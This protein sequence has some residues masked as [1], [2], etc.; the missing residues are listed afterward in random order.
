MSSTVTLVYRAVPEVTWVFMCVCDGI[1][2][3]W[4]KGNDELRAKR[5]RHLQIN[6]KLWELPW[7]F[8]NLDQFILSL[9]GLDLF[10]FEPLV[11]EGK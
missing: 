2:L 10:G 11:L 5:Q 9:T 4:L 7:C 6:P 1:C 8:S 3:G